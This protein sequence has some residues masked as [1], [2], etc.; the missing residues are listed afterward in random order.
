[1]SIERADRIRWQHALGQR[2][3]SPRAALRGVV[4]LSKT[5][6]QKPIGVDRSRGNL[7][8]VVAVLI[9]AGCASPSPS[10]LR[11]EIPGLWM[12]CNRP[13]QLTQ[14]CSIWSGATREIEINGVQMKISGTAD[15][16]VVVVM[17]TDATTHA[18]RGD[19][20]QASAK[21]TF[22]VVTRLESH[23][24]TIERQIPVVTSGEAVGNALESGALHISDPRD[25]LLWLA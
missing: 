18:F 21:A 1:M 23:G 24:V 2:K 9:L 10:D 22:E 4:G 25:P 3:G 12:T 8:W 6:A 13:Y 11:S 14:D 17:P 7:L 16:R 19:L 20:D 5:G 15:G